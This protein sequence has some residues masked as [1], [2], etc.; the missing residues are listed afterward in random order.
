MPDPEVF[1]I[2]L[3]GF[4]CG[5]HVWKMICYRPPEAPHDYG[6]QLDALQERMNTLPAITAELMD[7]KEF[8]RSMMVILIELQRTT[9]QETF[10]RA[11]R[12]AFETIQTQLDTVTELISQQTPVHTNGKKPGRPRKHPVEGKEE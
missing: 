3:V 2:F 10:H 4:V 8:L 1:V 12:P 5:F 7:T 6:S 11:F 9:Q